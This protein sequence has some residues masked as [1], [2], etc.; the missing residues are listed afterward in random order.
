MEPYEVWV[1]RLKINDSRST[2]AHKPFKPCGHATEHNFSPNL[3][4]HSEFVINERRIPFLLIVGLDV[5]VN[6]GTLSVNTFGHDTN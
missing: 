1:T 5:N 3:K 2:L 4:S 6:F